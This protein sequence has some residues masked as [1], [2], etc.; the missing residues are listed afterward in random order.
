[1]M[2]H[3]NIINIPNHLIVHKSLNIWTRLR[4]MERLL[5]VQQSQ[6]SFEP[7]LLHRFKIMNINVGGPAHRLSSMSS[8]LSL[9][10]VS[11]SKPC[12]QNVTFLTMPHI[13]YKNSLDFKV[14]T[15]LN[16]MNIFIQH[17]VTYILEW[18][19]LL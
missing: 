12:V 7:Q 10:F 16:R 3:P 1:M 9:H 6:N 18:Y 11:H 15:V 17:V 19:I 13:Q 5:F 4:K 8:Q 14:L 2:E